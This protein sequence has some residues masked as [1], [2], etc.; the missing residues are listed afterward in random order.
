MTT[1]SIH[2]AGIRLPELIHRLKPGDEVIIT[3]N[4]QPVA[5]LVGH[6]RAGL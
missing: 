6:V 3:E 1:V 4:D 5:K 2:D